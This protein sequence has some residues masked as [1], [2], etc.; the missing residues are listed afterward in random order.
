M[1]ILLSF[2]TLAALAVEPPKPEPKLTV[3][4]QRTLWRL[5]FESV[6]AENALMRTPEWTHSRAATEA[7]SAFLAARKA[8]GCEVTRTAAGEYDCAKPQKEPAK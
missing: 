1:K 5:A 8:E 2:L 6:Q 7:V 3:E 4:Q